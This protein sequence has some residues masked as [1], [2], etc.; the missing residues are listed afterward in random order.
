DPKAGLLLIPPS[1]TGPPE[2]A[3]AGMKV[4][5]KPGLLVRKYGEGTVAYIPWNATANYWEQA[6]TSISLLFNELIDQLIEGR[7]Q[8]ITD[9]HPLV[10]ISLMK[11]T[12]KNV[13]TL[14]LINNTAQLHGSGNR[15]I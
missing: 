9:A 8:V 2:L 4:S 1:Q 5:D 6:T 10:E 3:G 15:L 14:H 12:D 13:L 11:N 7:R